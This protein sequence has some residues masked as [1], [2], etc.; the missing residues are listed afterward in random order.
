M[1]IPGEE[2]YALFAAFAALA[3]IMLNVVS[4]SRWMENAGMDLRLSSNADGLADMIAKK[5]VG[6]DGN[7]DLSR[8]S[9]ANLT[10]NVQVKV[11]TQAFGAIPP[12]NESLYVSRRVVFVQG[13][14]V[15]MDVVVWK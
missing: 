10:G 11:G 13:R 8:V 9:S 4:A 12:S 1:F 5:W 3:L 7:L 2:V 6:S 15:T 14:P